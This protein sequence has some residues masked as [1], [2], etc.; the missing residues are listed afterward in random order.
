MSL[1]TVSIVGNL[2]KEPEQYKFASG[3]VKTTL[4]IAVNSFNRVRRERSSD[5]YRVET[6]DRLAE[7]AKVY[8]QKGNQIGVTGRLVM[9]TWVDR[10]GRDRTTPTVHVSQLALPQKRLSNNEKD[11]RELEIVSEI[12]LEMSEP[13][14]EVDTQEDTDPFEAA[15]DAVGDAVADA[16][17]ELAS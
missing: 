4:I 10:N 1:A 17:A 8:L 2:V 3:R 11:P 12:P 7:L 5:F 14:A 16:V 9:E 13:G 15:A 6:W